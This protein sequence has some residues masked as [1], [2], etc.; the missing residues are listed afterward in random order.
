MPATAG[1]GSTVEA[2]LGGLPAQAD[3]WTA[4]WTIGTSLGDYSP[5][6]ST[7]STISKDCSRNNVPSRCRASFPHH[8]ELV[9]ARLSAD[10]VHVGFLGKPFLSHA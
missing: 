2:S 7:M 8:L 3:G 4:R 9:H 6:I 10:H 5:M 1:R